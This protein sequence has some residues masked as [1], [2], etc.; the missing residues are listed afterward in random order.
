MRIL[1]ALILV[2]LAGTLYFLMFAN[3]GIPTGLSAV[4]NFDIQRYTGTWYEVARLDHG[5]EKGLTHVTAEYTLRDD[6]GLKVVNKG[7]N[8]KTG[9]WEQSEA[10]AYFTDEPNIG[11][12]KVSF[13]GPFYGGYNIIDLDDN[14]RYAMVTGPKM[15]FFWILSKDKTMAPEVLQKLVQ[16]AKGFGFKLDKMILVDQKEGTVPE[17]AAQGPTKGNN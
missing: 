11:M 10:K 2:S 17:E 3:I 16:K 7:F 14:Y 12:L 9:H 1:S 13:F 15:S 5:F 8:M 4:Q 6:G